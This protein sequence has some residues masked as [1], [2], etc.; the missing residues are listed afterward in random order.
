MQ[1]MGAEKIFSVS[2]INFIECEKSEKWNPGDGFWIY[3]DDKKQITFNG[4]TITADNPYTLKLTAGWN[5][6][7]TPFMTETNVEEYIFVDGVS[8]FK[9]TSIIP[10]FFSYNPSAGSYTQSNILQPFEGY[11]LFA[12]KDV[13]LQINPPYNTG[14]GKPVLLKIV[15]SEGNEIEDLSLK[16][17]ET[18][19][20]SAAGYDI[21]GNFT[22]FI[23][24]SW[25]INGNLGE[26]PS[27]KTTS[28]SITTHQN[29]TLARISGSSSI[30]S[31]ETGLIAVIDE[32]KPSSF[33]FD[34][35]KISTDNVTGIRHVSD[36]VLIAFNYG[37]SFDAAKTIIDEFN[38]KLVGFNPSANIFQVNTEID[39]AELDS[40][41]K[42]KNEVKYVARNII[43]DFEEMP[44]DI[45][46]QLMYP[47][48]T[49][50]YRQ[51]GL[52][53]VWEN[54]IPGYS[55]VVAVIDSGIDSDHY[56]LKD[57]IIGGYNF[58]NEMN[59][60]DT[61]DQSGHG[62]SVAG[63]ITAE[64]NNNYGIAGICPTCKIM[65]VKACSESGACTLFNIANSISYAVDNGADI[66]NLSLGGHFDADSYTAKV[67]Y[68]L[69]N[70]ARSKNVLLVAAAGNE[71]TDGSN[72][73]PAALPN[74]ISVAATDDND[75]R[76]PFS[77]YGPKVNVSAP[78]V[79]IFSTVI[80]GF[81]YVSGTSISAA[82]VSGLAGLL[83]SVRP[84]LSP[85]M[86]ESL[87]QTT[88]A[89]LNP[90]SQLP[91]RIDAESL[92]NYVSSLN[93][94]PIIHSLSVSSKVTEPGTTVTLSAIA[95][96]P[97]NDQMIFAWYSDSGNIIANGADASWQLPS[98][99]GDF[100]IKVTVRDS[101]GNE[102]YSTEH[103]L[104]INSELKK[105]EIEPDLLNL[106]S[107]E[108]VNFTAYCFDEDAISGLIEPIKCDTEWMV[109]D[110]SGNIDSD[111]SFIGIKPGTTIITSS[112]DG[113]SNHATVN[114]ISNTNTN[115]YAALYD[116]SCDT[117]WPVEKCNY[118][119]IAASN[120]DAE[121]FYTFKWAYHTISYSKGLISKFR[122]ASNEQEF[123]IV[124][125]SNHVYCVYRSTGDFCDD[126][127]GKAAL[128]LT[129]HGSYNG[130]DSVPAMSTDGN[131]IYITSKNGHLYKV[132][133]EGADRGVQVWDW[134]PDE[135]DPGNDVIQIYSSPTVRNDSN[136]G[137]DIIYLTSHTELGVSRGRIFAVRDSGAT[138][139]T[140]WIYPPLTETPVGQYYEF[141]PIYGDIDGKDRIIAG[142][143]FG[144]LYVLDWD[145]GSLYAQGDC[146][147]PCNYSAVLA[148]SPIDGNPYIYVGTSDD[149]R[150][151]DPST[152]NTEATFSDGGINLSFPPTYDTTTE[153]F[154]ILSKSN[155]AQFY[156]LRDNGAT[157]ST[158]WGPVDTTYET[159]SGTPANTP[160]LFNGGIFFTLYSNPPLM[161]T[162]DIT[163]GIIKWEKEYA[164]LGNYQ[165]S[166]IIVLN[167][168]SGESEIYF[169]SGNFI[170]D[171]EINFPPEINYFN[172]EPHNGVT[173]G[174]EI[175]YVNYSY[176]TASI[177][178]EDPNGGLNNISYFDLDKLE[179]D[180]SPINLDPDE[181][182]FH[183]GSTYANYYMSYNP[184]NPYTT[185]IIAPP[186]GLAPGTYT[187]V[188]TVY[189]KGGLTNTIP[190]SADLIIAD[191][192]PSFIS[193]A[194]NPESIFNNGA[195]STQLSI[196]IEDWNN[197]IS[198]VQVDVYPIQGGSNP[199]WTSLDC[200]S[201]FDPVTYQVTCT[202]D[203]TVSST[204]ALGTYSLNVRAQDATTTIE[205][206]TGN[207]S[208][209]DSESTLKVVGVDHYEITTTPASPIAAGT[210]YKA[211]I[212]AY[213]A[214]GDVISTYDNSDEIDITTS[215]PSGCSQLTLTGNPPTTVLNDLG[216]GAGT[217]SA[218]SFNGGIATFYFSNEI[219]EDTV[220]VTITDIILIS[221][222]TGNLEWVP[223]DLAEYT[224]VV[225]GGST[226]AGETAIL[227]ITAYDEFS[228]L[229]ENYQSTLPVLLQAT[230]FTG[231]IGWN[232]LSGNVST[233]D[234]LQ[235]W[236]AELA[237]GSFTN[238][239]VDVQVTNDTSETNDFTVRDQDSTPAI[240]E[241]TSITW[242][243]G[244]LD[245]FE[246]T[247]TDPITYPADHPEIYATA[248]IQ[249]RALDAIGNTKIGYINT[250]PVLIKINSG[251]SQNIR[252]E[253][254]SGND[255]TT[256][257]QDGTGHLPADAFSSGFATIKLYNEAPGTNEPFVE[258]QDSL[259]GSKISNSTSLIW[260]SLPPSAIEIEVVDPVGVD[261]EVHST[262]RLQVTIKDANGNPVTDYTPPQNLPLTITG[263][264]T[265]TS[266][267]W[268]GFDCDV[269]SNPDGSGSIDVSTTN[270]FLGDGI[271]LITIYNEEVEVHQPRVQELDL[272]LSDSTTIS[273]DY[274][275]F[276]SFDFKVTN[277]DPFIS[278]PSVI[279]TAVM[280]LTAYDSWGNIITTY[281]N[282]APV[283]LN[284]ITGTAVTTTWTGVNVSADTFDD[285]KAWIATNSFTSGLETIMINN[286]TAEDQQ[287]T[288]IEYDTANPG[289]SDT[290]DI[291][292]DP[293]P[294]DYFEI[295]A[296][297]SDAQV[298]QKID[299]SITAYDG[300]GN[301][302]TDYTNANGMDLFVETGSSG[303]DDGISW[304]TTNA[305]GTEF[306]DH[307]DGTATIS[308]DVFNNGVYSFTQ[309]S[310]THIDTGVRIRCNENSTA[311]YD[312]TPVLVNWTPGPLG[313]F[314][315]VA[316]PTALETDPSSNTTTVTITA[317]D[318]FDNIKIDFSSNV[319]LDAAPI[320]PGST[321]TWSGTGISGIVSPGNA[322][323]AGTVFSN[324][325][326]HVSLTDT[327]PEGPID[328]TVTAG[329]TASTSLPADSPTWDPGTLDHLIVRSEAANA[330][331]EVTDELLAVGDTLNLWA[332]GYDFYDNYIGDINVEWSTVN[333]GGIPLDAIIPPTSGV[334]NVVFQPSTENSQGNIR[335]NNGSGVIDE[336]GLI[337][338]MSATPMAPEAAAT[339]GEGEIVLSWPAVTKFEDGRDIMNP[340]TT[341]Y[342]KIWM[343]DSSGTFTDPPVT[344]GP[345]VNTYT[346]AVPADIDVWKTYYYVVKTW[347]N[348][349]SGVDVE[350]TYSDETSAAATANQF[351]PGKVCPV[352]DPNFYQPPSTPGYLNRPS[353]I[354]FGEMS[355]NPPYNYIYVADT[356]N[357]RISV[358]D[359]DC[360]FYDTWG[361]F[362]HED[363]QFRLPT[364]ILY[365]SSNLYIV[366]YMNRMQIFETSTGS[367]V[368]SYEITNPLKIEWGPSGKIIVATLDSMIYIIDSTSG[369]IDSSF[370]VAN[371]KGVAY[372]DGNIYV[373]DA[374]SNV[375][376]IYD[377][378]G[379]ETG[380]IGVPGTG[381]GELNN[382]MDL[383]V[384]DLG[385]IYV[386]DMGNDRI[387]IFNR[388]TKDLVNVVG[389]L[390]TGSSNLRSPTG[391]AL[392]STVDSAS[393]QYKIWVADRL[394][395]RVVEF[396]PPAP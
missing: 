262:V 174:A 233:P 1:K 162:V 320:D 43:L 194:F 336:T 347:Y 117:T 125:S 303:T 358:F 153:T 362:G 240:S 53:N 231:T 217:I 306:S 394:N 105:I 161:G 45:F 391:I 198:S 263:G 33:P 326:A 392:S 197:V 5:I 100:Q 261:P 171:L 86:I 377:L 290:E 158:V 380:E 367:F 99:R 140:E 160:V 384:D 256:Y 64:I 352:Y 229:I 103:V 351:S 127:N 12:K 41:L 47:E 108:I 7:T 267:F 191:I 40:L 26:A 10:R 21:N 37:I 18:I 357:H 390:G 31:D 345:N 307:G 293:G 241:T 70:Y 355:P 334:P 156:A 116:N 169:S 173:A 375:I 218:N 282:T 16:A 96:D 111:G 283:E 275:P 60:E 232:D 24:V 383:T 349:G 76:A 130:S 288:A 87:I 115:L 292:W 90:D 238:G 3:S 168:D 69:A 363:G 179:L 223:A 301:I 269:I 150:K 203:L 382:P 89:T 230:G 374:T 48:S 265:S 221:A 79:D 270:P 22:D 30:L 254:A 193:A 337:K 38:G 95:D 244:P 32:A 251:V 184:A 6:V 315:I 78:G 274:G 278:N 373:S 266:I 343:S 84:D 302:K 49:W 216:N 243:A 113:I 72:Y 73:Y 211:E 137:E 75:L 308:G 285:G 361:S 296:T 205:E 322:N 376:K 313:S 85:V 368:D 51:I 196:T 128:Q 234:P 119:G 35:D 15:D 387:Q 185:T 151:I 2:G 52:D 298:G 340:E 54:L 344:I 188:A 177:F 159:Y 276:T 300:L 62:T 372:A 141:T 178:A 228:N 68:S 122:A 63:I 42:T 314:D 93:G 55:P 121:W 66:V 396:I 9:S 190:A 59:P 273:W 219:A 80:D 98:M 25:E 227:T 268:S 220:Q 58:L 94:A 305:P 331:S 242:D 369:E 195:E 166:P 124:D 247:I 77:N 246:L 112:L 170:L 50:G 209:A 385:N 272:S 14:A 192:E 97:E 286:A 235:P 176:A 4:S 249:I 260:D 393:G 181:E 338:V 144:R 172:L 145:T 329:A 118:S 142:N 19:E 365:N 324:G 126:F 201:G 104:V 259:P 34:E 120:Q 225:T 280:T 139:S 114:I 330:G 258:E 289:I 163:S 46:D 381:Y 215:C 317:K 319:A 248:T 295:S 386:V 165:S 56:E 239:Q 29:M 213:Y 310:N 378:S 23:P 155:P 17:G 27:E 271:A 389:S 364:G 133:I 318:I 212:K 304:Y 146:A 245:D 109:S 316:S 157:F 348:P 327:V 206:L 187:I 297:S 36:Q 309:V 134:G 312:Q 11:L 83:K 102:A 154:Y 371:S 257:P 388:N 107:G 291:T 186:K 281:H 207:I 204:T 91:G 152:G 360:N 13:T 279:D 101:F 149:F 224:F 222:S 182:M 346:Y 255:L 74:V 135:I 353:D 253:D 341:I 359:E 395:Q 147:G 132:G 183:K 123:Y 164:S 366:D 199:N 88:S 325:I 65:P 110:D 323:L 236:N 210:N 208:P 321:L 57:K 332:A 299:F 71:N 250:N 8:F 354:A 226:N 148:E 61:E 189:D 335:A 81:D 200:S 131:Y 252:W 342:Y 284:I 277:P 39:F 138:N 20:L 129:S 237:P 92:F 264:F 180:L 202:A 143:S 287:V 350:S 175:D 44:N 356:D 339:G 214:N 370:S 167:P 379:N 333:I 106:I 311:H 82:Y 136:T 67:L 328:L 294:L 28:I